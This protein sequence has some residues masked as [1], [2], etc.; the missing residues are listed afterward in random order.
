MWQRWVGPSSKVLGPCLGL[1]WLARWRLDGWG[2]DGARSRTGR[3]VVGNVV[4]MR[5]RPNEVY[6]K[7]LETARGD[8]RRVKIAIPIDPGQAGL[9][10]KDAF[11]NF[12][13]GYNVDFSPESGDKEIRATPY[14]VQV[15][16]V[17]RMNCADKWTIVRLPA[18]AE[19]PTEQYPEIDPL[20]RKVGEALAYPVAALDRIRANTLA[21]NWSARSISSAP[22]PTRWRLDGRS[23]T[24]RIGVGN[25][26]R[27]RGR[28]NEVY[29][30]VL[31][32]ARGGVS[33]SIKIAIPIDP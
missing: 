21:R 24:G 17:E 9:A 33:P 6:D 3:I 5:G 11:M 1:G 31:E 30:K 10:Q 22:R 8:T 7:V 12:L 2:D 14:A 28:P 18:L 4:R 25:V 19:A 32:T 13:S 23:R 16:L 20:G 15:R 27:M 26:V 29:D